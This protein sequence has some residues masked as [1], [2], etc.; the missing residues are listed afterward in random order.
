MN[1]ILVSIVGYTAMV[2]TTVSYFPQMVQCFKTKTA[3]GVSMGFLVTILFG[4]VLW[5]IYGIMIGDLPL[6]IGN[7]IAVA[8]I[9]PVFIFKVKDI[10]KDKEDALRA[11]TDN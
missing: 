3:R 9:T 2:L 4:L 5:E 8:N 7:V 6:I 11:Q 10:L 1:E